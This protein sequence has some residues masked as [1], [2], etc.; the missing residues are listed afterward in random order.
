MG[1]PTGFAPAFRRVGGARLQDRDDAAEGPV[2][3]ALDAERLHIPKLAPVVPPQGDAGAIAAAAKMLVE[4]QNP[5][6]IC[7]R[8]ARTPAGITNLV[9]LAE[10]LQCGVID[11]VGRMNF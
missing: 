8:M 9:E 10:T 3:L 7:D 1:R 5:V 2:F 11:N 6:I 4:A